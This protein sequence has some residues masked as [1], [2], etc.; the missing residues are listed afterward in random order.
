M[1]PQTRAILDGIN[2][3]IITFRHTY[4][5][6][7]RK[8][9]LSYNEMLVLYTIFVDGSCTQK[10]ICDSYLL[11]KQTINS[12]FASMSKRGLLQVDPA[13]GQGRE[14][15]FVFTAA[16]R[17]Y[18]EPLMTALTDAEAR[19]FAA[20]G[21]ENLKTLMALLTAHTQSLTQALEEDE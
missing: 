3:A 13:L 20:S 18:A 16:G 2:T 14:K 9:H 6:W 12:V 17:R 21:A 7:S 4:S 19:A 8:H 11:P 1:D 15:A 10:Q 5:E